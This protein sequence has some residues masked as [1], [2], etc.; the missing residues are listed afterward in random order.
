[1]FRRR[2]TGSN[3]EAA[4]RRSPPEDHADSEFIPIPAISGYARPDGHPVLAMAARAS[5]T[6]AGSAPVAAR[7]MTSCPWPMGPG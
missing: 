3:G 6:T 1:G 2:M 4:S 7:A 5:W